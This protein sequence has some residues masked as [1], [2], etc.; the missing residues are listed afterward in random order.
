MNGIRLFLRTVVWL[1]FFAASGAAF[2][3]DVLPFETTVPH[4][5]LVDAK[6]GTRLLREERRRTGAARQHEQADDHGDG[7]RGF[8]GRDRDRRNRISNQRECL[9]AGRDLHRAAPPCMPT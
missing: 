5:I 2:G 7:F 8:E 1:V 9:E 4:A 3:Q 6:S